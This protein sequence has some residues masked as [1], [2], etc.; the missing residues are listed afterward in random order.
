MKRIAAAR[1]ER[2]EVQIRRQRD[3]GSNAFEAGG[4]VIGAHL[5]HKPVTFEFV[6]AGGPACHGEPLRKGLQAI[7]RQN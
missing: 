6:E 5:F 1:V 3:Q 7:H 2:R 4:A